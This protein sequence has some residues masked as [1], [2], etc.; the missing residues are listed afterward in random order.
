[1]GFLKIICPKSIDVNFFQY[2]RARF[3]LSYTLS[4]RKT[5][6]ERVVSS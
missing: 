5:I 1:M 4:R 3:P 2:T 6:A